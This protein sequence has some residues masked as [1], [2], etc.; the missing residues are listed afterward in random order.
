MSFK[1][2]F[3]I[4]TVTKPSISPPSPPSATYF[5]FLP[6]Q[7]VG[8]VGPIGRNIARSLLIAGANVIVNSRSENRLEKLAKDLSEHPRL[9]P[10]H[11]SLL[12]GK[13][14][15][16]VQRTLSYSSNDLDH[17]IAHGAVRWWANKNTGFSSM[18]ESRMTVA[19]SGFLE[20]DVDEFMSASQQSLR[21]QFSAAQHLMPRLQG[22][23]SEMTNVYSIAQ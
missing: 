17:V 9:I 8:G 7:I 2:I 1:L 13:A 21:L 16:T 22:G 10:V 18:D 23:R 20:N 19:T 4:I 11:G 15:D 6:S 5:P 14:A 12:P 3:N